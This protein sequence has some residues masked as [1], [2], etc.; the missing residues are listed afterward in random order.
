MKLLSIIAA[1]AVT[2]GGCATPAGQ[3]KDDDL[4]WTRLTVNETYQQVYRNV[5]E[6]FRRC[7]DA[8]VAEG[9]L[10]TDIK[11]GEFDFYLTDIFGGRSSWVAGFV[12]IEAVDDKSARLAVGVNKNYDK[13]LLG[14]AGGIR[15][16][17]VAWSSAKYDCS[18]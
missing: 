15:R 9:N 1:A 4:A 17:I 12:K 18:P 8:F 2:M 5:R 6:G 11:A 13:P 7:G 3:F 16:N 10:F 14:E